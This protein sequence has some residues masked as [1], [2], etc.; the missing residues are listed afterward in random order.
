MAVSSPSSSSGLVP[1]LREDGGFWL[2]NELIDLHARHLG[3]RGLYVYC[4]LAR[5][6]SHKHYP[7]VRDLASLTEIS[8]RTVRGLLRRLHEY[9]LLN[10]HDLANIAG[11]TDDDVVRDGHAPDSNPQES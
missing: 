7:T 5:T 11:S 6:A 3:S 2:P 4:V 9:G 10:D 8:P 1:S